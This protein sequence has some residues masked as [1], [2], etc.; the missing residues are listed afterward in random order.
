MIAAISETTPK[1]NI[2]GMPN[3]DVSSNFAEATAHSS[4]TGGAGSQ[5]ALAWLSKSQNAHG[6]V[7][8][9]GRWNRQTTVDWGGGDNTAQ[10]PQS[11][12]AQPRGM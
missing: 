4:A 2:E 7:Q 5:G 11:M 1:P 10:L 3:V 6:K 8:S 9:L 12:R